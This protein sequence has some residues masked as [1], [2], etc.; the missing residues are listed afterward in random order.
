M[1]EL[2]EALA[3]ARQMND[4]LNGKWIESS[5]YMDSPHKFAFGEHYG[6]K[7]HTPEEYQDILNGKTIGQVTADGSWLLV[8]LEPGYMLKLGEGGERI[9]FHQSED[10][11]PEKHQL[12]LHFVDGS[13]LTV[14]VQGWGLVAAYQRP[15]AP[16]SSGKISPLSDAFTFEHF[17]ELFGEATDRK[18][19]KSFIVSDP[20]ISGVGNGYLQDI[21]F[22]ARIHPTRKNADISEAE[23]RALYDAIRETLKQA[24]ELGGRDTER[25]LYNNPGKYQKLLDR[26]KVGQPC[27][28]CRAPIKKIQYL[29]GSCYLCSD[30]Q[31]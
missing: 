27:P 8:P 21:L 19:I 23:K 17:Q 15:G 12:L 14:S 10:T 5:I 7:S 4:E 18:S 28:E 20:G 16:Q 3:I 9:L 29:G 11:L 31:I 6:R 25:D 24:V 22:R 1:I 30:C 2:P 13:Y 26:R